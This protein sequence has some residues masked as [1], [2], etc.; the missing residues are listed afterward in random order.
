MFNILINLFNFFNY[1]ISFK[2]V[3]NICEKHTK[4]QLLIDNEIFELF[5]VVLF[6]KDILLTPHSVLNFISA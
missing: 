3:Y 2:E 5:C 1:L 4:Q 6:H